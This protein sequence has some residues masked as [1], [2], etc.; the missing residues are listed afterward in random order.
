MRTR[1]TRTPLTLL[2][3]LSIPNHILRARIASRWVHP[4]SGRVYNLSFSSPRVPGVDDVTGEPLIQR[5]DDRPEVFD[6]RLEAYERET[7]PL[8]GYYAEQARRGALGGGSGLRLVTLEGETSD[9]IWPVLERTVRGLFPAVKTRE[10][11]AMEERRRSA[12]PAA[13]ARALARE[14]VAAVDDVAQE[15]QPSALA[16]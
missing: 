11:V 9:E 16:K 10:E 12:S 8:L 13:K 7:A 15:T 1:S 6:R 2:T 4:A 14:A 3:A 5:P